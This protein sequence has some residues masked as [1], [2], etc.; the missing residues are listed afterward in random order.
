MAGR[1][2]ESLRLLEVDVWRSMAED[3]VA[4]RRLLEEVKTN[5]GF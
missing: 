2:G 5:T 1:S 4:W 3:R